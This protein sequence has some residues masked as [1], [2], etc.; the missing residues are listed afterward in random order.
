MTREDVIRYA[1]MWLGTPYVHQGRLMGV[2]V[3]CIGLVA[4]VGQY[5]GLPYEDRRGYAPTGQGDFYLTN[6]FVKWMD[7]VYTAH[8]QPGDVAC[9]WVRKPTF[10]CHCGILTPVGLI[11]VHSIIGHVAEH[12]MDAGWK[13]RF[14]CAFRFRG[15]KD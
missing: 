4:G 2:G 7:P 3:D 8:A 15:M 12:V 10:I 13:K 9:F 1:R 5:F 11:H 6:E 14:A